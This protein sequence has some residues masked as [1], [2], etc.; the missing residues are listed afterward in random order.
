MGCGGS[1]KIQLEGPE[2]PMCH[3]MEKIDIECYDACFE[4]TSK[5]IQNLEVMR[6]LLFDDYMDCMYQTGGLVHKCPNPQKALCASIWRLGVDNKGKASE[7]GFNSETMLFEGACNSEE[8]NS[9]ANN[10]TAYI[11]RIQEVNPDDCKAIAEAI[12]ENMK[13]ISDNQEKCAADIK[14]KFASDKMKMIAS[15]EALKVN[16]AKATCSANTLKECQQRMKLIKENIPEMMECCKAEKFADQQAC[17]DKA[18]K[19]KE[20]CNLGIAWDVVEAKERKNMTAKQIHACYTE[21]CRLRKEMFEKM[22]AATA[23]PQ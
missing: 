17:V 16:I 7:I 5:N 8:G 15:C 1:K 23:S 10:L 14:E 12:G 18:M 19:S 6:K 2:R 22:A 3:K 13:H 21:K 11:K 4:N 20:T 9:A